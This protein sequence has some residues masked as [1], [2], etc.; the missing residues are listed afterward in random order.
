MK[1]FVSL[2][3]ATLLAATPLATFALTPDQEGA[4]SVHCESI[5]QTLK[6]VQ[7]EDSR[8]RVYL[9]GYYETILNKFM[10]PLNLRLVKNNL[11]DANLTANQ[12]TFSTNKINFNDDFIDYQKSLDELIAID[13]KNNPTDFYDK[14]I[15][16]REKRSIMRQDVQALQD[17]ITA[18]IGFVGAL[19][20]QL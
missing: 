5:R 14:L 9:G 17:D 20:G 19:K 7:H 10:V 18:H 13:C 4:I 16:V 15:L 1:H 11:V 8:T 6:T 3:C 2:L 12:A